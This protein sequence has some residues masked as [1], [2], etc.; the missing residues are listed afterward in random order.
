[1]PRGEKLAYGTCS[2]LTVFRLNFSV[3]LR[4]GLQKGCSIA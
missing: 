2:N 1:M 4:Y 3:Y